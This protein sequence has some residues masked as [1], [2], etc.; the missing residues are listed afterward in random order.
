MSRF[1]DWSKDELEWKCIELERQVEDLEE[2]IKRLK[3][4][5]SHLEYRINNELEPRLK[6]ERDS[7]DRW[8]TDPERGRW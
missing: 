8:A 1:S 2:S 6:S 5:N 4:E 7:Y 3:S